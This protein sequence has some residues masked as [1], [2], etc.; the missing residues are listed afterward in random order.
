MALHTSTKIH[1]ANEIE[2]ET[3]ESA[4][5]VDKLG[6]ASKWSFLVSTPCVKQSSNGGTLA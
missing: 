1:A 5:W 4:S 6:M 3:F 2:P